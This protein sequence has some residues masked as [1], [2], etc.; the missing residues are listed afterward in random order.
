MVPKCPSSLWSPSR[1][2]LA[3]SMH[4]SPQLLAQALQHWPQRRRRLRRLVVSLGVWLAAPAHA[5][6]S[7]VHGAQGLA[8]GLSRCH[9][10]HLGLLPSLLL[11]QKQRLAVSARRVWP[12]AQK[13]DREPMDTRSKLGR[14]GPASPKAFHHHVFCTITHHTQGKQP[15]TP[16]LHSEPGWPVPLALGRQG[17]HSPR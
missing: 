16:A 1:T 6:C 4:Q 14:L 10:R 13:V 15:T 5:T 17:P 11:Q 3:C 8:T 2:G 7:H 9:N 12:E